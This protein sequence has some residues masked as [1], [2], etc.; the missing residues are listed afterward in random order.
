[1]GLFTRQS[2]RRGREDDLILGFGTP[3]QG[4]GTFSWCA[5]EALVPESAHPVVEVTFPAKPGE[6]AATARWTLRQ[7]C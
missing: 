4:A 6:K 1:M 5:Y 7:R 3:G 2:L